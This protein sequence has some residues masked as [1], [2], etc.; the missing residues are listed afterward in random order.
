MIIYRQKYGDQYVIALN[1]SMIGRAMY[2]EK[3]EIHERVNF[4]MK[5]LIFIVFNKFTGTLFYEPCIFYR[6]AG[7]CA[8]LVIFFLKVI[9]RSYGYTVKFIMSNYIQFELFLTI[10]IDRHRSYLICHQFW[11]KQSWLEIKL[12]KLTTY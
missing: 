9:S 12:D 1:N 10:P 11:L 4:I 6:W 8:R 2:R 5:K 7:A 3:E